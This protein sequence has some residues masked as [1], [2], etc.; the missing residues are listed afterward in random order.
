M[1]PQKKEVEE[2][3]E[4]AETDIPRAPTGPNQAPARFVPINIPGRQMY[5]LPGMP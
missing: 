4:A 5:V 3:E 2:K 1:M